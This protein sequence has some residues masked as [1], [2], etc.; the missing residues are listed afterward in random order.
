MGVLSACNNQTDHQ[1]KE[2]TQIEIRQAIELAR[3]YADSN[4]IISAKY[5]SEAIKLA[6]KADDTLHYCQASLL[7]ALAEI[8]QQKLTEAHRVISEILPLTI[9]AGLP[10]EQFKAYYLLGV[11]ESIRLDF[12]ESYHYYDSAFVMIPNLPWGGDHD[13]QLY[14]NAVS[15]MS[16]IGS[17]GIRLGQIRPAIGMMSDYITTDYPLELRMYAMGHL[18]ELYRITGSYDTALLYANQAIDIASRLHRPTYLIKQFGMKANIFYQLGQYDSCI[19]YNKKAE[20][21]AINQKQTRDLPY[22]YNNLASVYHKTSNL[23]MAIVYF[24]KSLKLKEK[25]HDSAGIAVTLSNLGII[26]ENWGNL[27]RTRQYFNQALAINLKLKNQDGIAKGYI[28]LGELFYTESQYD[29]A[30]VYFMKALEIRRKQKDN[31]GCIVALDGLGRS[32]RLHHGTSRQAMEYFSEAKKLAE[33][34]H[35]GY[36]MASLSY[37]TGELNRLSGNYPLARELLRNSIV[38][39]R[40]EKLDDIAM[41]ATRSL[42]EAELQE[43]DQSELLRLFIN[44]KALTDSIRNKERDDI[45]AE[46]LVKHETEQKEKEN[47]LL[48]K[49]LDYQQLRLKSQTIQLIGLLGIVFLLVVVGTVIYWFYRKKALAYRI[50]VEQHIAAVRNETS[51]GKRLGPLR[52]LEPET[53][54]KLEINDEVLLK[55]LFDCMDQENP[56]LNPELSL[57]D[58]CKKLNTNRT[59]LSTVI[60]TALGKNFNTFINEYRVAEARRIL[61]GGKGHLYS[62]EDVGRMSGFNTKSSFYS[63]FKA[64]I[65]VPPAYFRD[66]IMESSR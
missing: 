20:V 22:I 62:V 63:C 46:M 27:R 48:K 36:W 2:S 55:R 14:E 3:H 32:F 35:A 51:Q 66:Y 50:I 6:E 21:A 40:E 56:F 24:S 42:L 19:W 5:V 28:N 9:K 43:T 1:N 38:V 47:L 45:T 59:Y 16:G 4:A 39:A 33:Q 30:I 64:I 58:L 26:Y 7:L 25:S 13:S 37:E 44:Y 41:D 15:V 18:T 54:N 53:L 31:Y 60:N 10:E 17:L 57:E 29:S 23:P 12:T 49:E 52:N 61:S 65:G 11:L 8:R 34:I